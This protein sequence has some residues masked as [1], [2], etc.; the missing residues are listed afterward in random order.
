MVTRLAI[1]VGC[2]KNASCEAIARLVLSAIDLAP[3]RP[4]E[5]RL[6]SS[7][8]KTGET[9]MRQAAETLGFP[10]VFLPEGS[11]KSA[12]DRLA[13]NS[14]VVRR[15]TGVGSLAEA[16][17]LVGGGPDYKLVVPRLSR[18]GATCAIAAAEEGRLP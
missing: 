11:L 12:L 16:A 2:R 7:D 3:G 1:G 13:T 8:R 5:A 4:Y 6:F 10:L 18:D 15:I 17:A 14:D 9:G